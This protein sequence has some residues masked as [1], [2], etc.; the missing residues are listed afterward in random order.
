MPR[1]GGYVSDELWT[2]VQR[3]RPGAGTSA[4][5]QEALKQLV[6][7]DDPFAAV[8]PAEGPR[9]ARAVERLKLAANDDYRDGYQ[10]GL[11]L[12]EPRRTLEDL[13]AIIA[14]HG[15]IDLP[16]QEQPVI[17]WEMLDML[18]EDWD[19]LAWLQRLNT[20]WDADW[21]ELY[22]ALSYT[23]VD[24]NPRAGVRSTAFRAGFVAALKAAWS[25][26][27]GSSQA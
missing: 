23:A 7:A 19:V 21:D 6:R 25:A 5:L 11:R 14:K 13:D 17:D 8:R 27:I 3:A 2:Q 12:L 16:V 9:V 15:P 18:A 22:E 20:R 1:I 4:L 26:V 10:T 24:G